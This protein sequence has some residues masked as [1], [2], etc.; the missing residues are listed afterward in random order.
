MVL[1]NGGGA[2]GVFLIGILGRIRSWERGDQLIVRIASSK[3]T[4]DDDGDIF[5]RRWRQCSVYYVVLTTSGN[6]LATSI[7]TNK[8]YEQSEM[9]SCGSWLEIRGGSVTDGETVNLE[10]CRP[11]C[12]PKDRTLRRESA[13]YVTSRRN[14]EA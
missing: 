5:V 11:V 6:I 14:S 2:S 8:E 7:Q 4:G 9:S 10:T 1:A 3:A 13:Q 12:K